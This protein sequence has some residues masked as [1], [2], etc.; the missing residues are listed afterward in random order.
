MQKNWHKNLTKRGRC[1]EKLAQKS[2]KSMRQH[3]PGQDIWAELGLEKIADDNI[4]RGFGQ[5]LIS[6]QHTIH[7]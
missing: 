4:S 2:H 3:L 5:D 7:I 1:A 6:R